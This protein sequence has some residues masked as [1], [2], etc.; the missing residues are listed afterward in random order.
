MNKLVS[1]S[2]WGLVIAL[3][4]VWGL[5][6]AALG[7]GLRNCASLISGSVMTG[8]ALFFMA[9][10]WTITKRFSGIFVIV[11]FASAF[12]LFDALLLSLPLKHG[13]IGNPVF[14]FFM[15]AAAFILIISLIKEKLKANPAGQALTGGLTAVLAVNLFPLVRHATGV[16]ACVVPG[17]TYPLSLHLIHVAVL[18]SAL[19]VPLGFSLGA[20][21][22]TFEPRLVKTRNAT[23][24]T[25]ALSPAALFGCLIIL[26]LFRL[27]S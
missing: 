21:L 9:V 2:H 19:L 5:S 17:G 7:M 25:N 12:K 26:M 3:G 11:L 24:I 27:I 18:V 13:A 4:A 14:A 20:K 15:E 8:V 6:E 23:K 1:K 16:P 10:V 22:V